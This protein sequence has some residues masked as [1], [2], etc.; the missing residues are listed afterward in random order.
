[1]GGVFKPNGQHGM[2]RMQQSGMD[3]DLYSD[4]H[5]EEDCSDVDVIGDGKE[6][7]S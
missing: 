1:M 7:M 4:E 6:Y 3:H 2:M 5:S